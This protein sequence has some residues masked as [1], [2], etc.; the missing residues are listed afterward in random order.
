MA[1][2]M[3]VLGRAGRSDFRTASSEPDLPFFCF[4]EEVSCQRRLAVLLV[5]WRRDG[6]APAV[7]DVA[8]SCLDEDWNQL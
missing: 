7:P 3:E 6:V 4:V 2:R 8:Y 5:T 1:R